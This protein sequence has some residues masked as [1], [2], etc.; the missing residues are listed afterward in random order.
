MARIVKR[1]R[2]RLSLNGFALIVFTFSM[3]AWLITT[4][5]VNTIN[6]SLTMKIQ[7]LENKD[8][9]YEVAQAANMDQISENIISVTGN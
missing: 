5:L 3:I 8:R 6:T 4:L 7:T 9:V 2:R 1:K